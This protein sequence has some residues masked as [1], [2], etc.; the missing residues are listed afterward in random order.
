MQ[1]LSRIESVRAPGSG[2][3]LPLAAREQPCY[4]DPASDGRAPNGSMAEVCIMRCPANPLGEQAIASNVP[5]PRSSAP[6]HPTRLISTFWAFWPTP[7]SSHP[8]KI[9]ALVMVCSRQDVGIFAA[10][11]GVEVW[12][13]PGPCRLPDFGPS[14]AIPSRGLS[15]DEIAGPD[16]GRS[17][18]QSIGTACTR[19]PCRPSP[20]A[21]PLQS[22]PISHNFSSP[23]GSP[24]GEAAVCGYRFHRAN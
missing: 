2:I 18:T 24:D 20:Q 4:D 10:G 9:T 17:P 11:L 21:A 6:S 13:M 7:R 15:G 5:C 3:T 16:P 23:R 12:P 14:L 22:G 1:A 19:V 8:A